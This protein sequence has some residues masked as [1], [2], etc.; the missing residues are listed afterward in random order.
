MVS[1]A[2][3][4][5][6]SV[7]EVTQR[8]IN[9]DIVL[10]LSTFAIEASILDVVIGPFLVFSWERTTPEMARS[11]SRLIPISTSVA[12]A[13]PLGSPRGRGIGGRFWALVVIVFCPS[14]SLC[15]VWRQLPSN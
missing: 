15:F 11:H 14:F 7:V 12:P 8:C 6:G 10:D 3:T 9:K 4:T 1:T 5:T 13:R 2:P